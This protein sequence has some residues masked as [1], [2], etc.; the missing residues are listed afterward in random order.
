M[1]SLRSILRAKSLFALLCIP[2]LL[3]AACGSTSNPAA[4]SNNPNAN[5]TLTIGSKLDTESEII[6]ELYSLALRD[7]GF[8]VNEKLAFG[9]N[10]IIFQ[11]IK[12]GQLDLYP[13]FTATGLQALNKTSSLNDQQDYDTVKAGYK[14]QFNIDWLNYSPLNDTYAICMRQDEANQLG[15]KTISDLEKKA[16]QV[17]FYLPSDSTY[18]FNYLKSKYNLTQASFKSV[19]QV[20]ISIAFQEV[21]NGKNQ[22][23]ANF[24]YSTDQRI[25]AD[26]LVVLQDNN[27]AFPAYHP[28]PIVRDSVLK[29]SPD[30]ATTLNKLAP[31]ITNT[32]SLQLQSQLAQFQ[33]KN[34]GVSS[35]EALYQVAK[36]FLTSKGFC[37]K[38]GC[39]QS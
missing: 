8:K 24:C 3:L 27:N 23:K 37:N 38:Y 11:G 15:I 31:D 29:K 25:Q 39:T 9:N 12:S 5:V 26:N 18:V 35:T 28:A 20:D 17:S 14:Q 4:N 1:Q 30:I 13:E 10:T 16:S 21:I 22:A 34:P 2:M 36:Q 19:N 7:Q 33:A 6:A 32:V